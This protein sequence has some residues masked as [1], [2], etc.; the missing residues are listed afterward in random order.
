[1]EGSHYAQIPGLVKNSESDSL[2]DDRL[3][4]RTLST[5][6]VG[7]AV[8]TKRTPCAKSRGLPKTRPV[9]RQ[10]RPPNV[11]NA[12]LVAMCETHKV[13]VKGTG[14]DGKVLK[15]DMVNVLAERR[16]SDRTGKDDEPIDQSMP[17]KYR[18]RRE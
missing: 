18:R 13:A 3:Y 4:T 15:A 12:E 9:C 17:V 7:F 14:H 6:T 1:M 2:R 8:S 16:E 10:R 5:D 11:W